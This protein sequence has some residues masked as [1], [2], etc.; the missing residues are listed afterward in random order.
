MVSHDLGV[1]THMCDRLAVMQ[2]GR[3]VERLSSADLV[4]GRIGEEYTRNLMVAS[5]GFQRK[6]AAA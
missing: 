5:K 2:N 3:V 6:G 4:A 1:V